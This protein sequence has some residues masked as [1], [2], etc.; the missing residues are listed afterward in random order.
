MGE[1]VLYTYQT[2]TYCPPMTERNAEKCRGNKNHTSHWILSC[3]ARVADPAC[4]HYWV[5]QIATL[6]RAWTPRSPELSFDSFSHLPAVCACRLASYSWSPSCLPPGL[7]HRQH[8]DPGCYLR[9]TGNHGCDPVCDPIFLS[10]TACTAMLLLFSSPICCCKPWNR[11]SRSGG[12]GPDGPGYSL[13]HGQGAPHACL[14]M[15]MSVQPSCSP[16]S[17]DAKVDVVLLDAS[18]AA[19]K[20]GLAFMGK[21]RYSKQAVAVKS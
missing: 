12:S 10:S 18:E 7:L 13:C 21:H 15:H 6:S 19:L 1:M 8:V 17:K 5:V 14:H 4:I 11:E 20:K 16:G 9:A 3:T 2:G